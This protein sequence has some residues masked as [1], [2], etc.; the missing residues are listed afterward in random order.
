MFGV[1]DIING[2]ASAVMAPAVTTDRY[3]K[4]PEDTW[5]SL[6]VL[7]VGDTVYQVSHYGRHNSTQGEIVTLRDIKNMKVTVDVQIMEIH[8]VRASQLTPDELAQLGK[9]EATELLGF[10]PV[11]AMGDRRGWFMHVIPVSD[12]Q[13][14]M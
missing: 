6:N 11:E 8:L 4:T 1:S 7:E 3:K 13:P 5:H 10:D 12:N 9:R 14:K 2:V